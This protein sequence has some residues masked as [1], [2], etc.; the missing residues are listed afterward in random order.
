MGFD[1]QGN[2]LGMGKGYYDRYLKTVQHAFKIGVF[3]T[4]QR[5]DQVPT[6]SYD[7]SVDLVVTDEKMYSIRP[8]SNS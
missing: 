5:V 3:F 4:E 6:D 2:R 8:F 1:P 7:V